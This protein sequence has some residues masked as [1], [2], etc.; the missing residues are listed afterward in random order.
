MVLRFML[1]G[2]HQSPTLFNNVAKGLIPL[3]VNCRKTPVSG[4]SPLNRYS[5]V[6]THCVVTHRLRVCLL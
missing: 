3:L 5:V 2:Y 1:L 4:G 6:W